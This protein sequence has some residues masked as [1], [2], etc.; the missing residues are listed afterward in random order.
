MNL[1]QQTKRE[2]P[3]PNNERPTTPRGTPCSHPRAEASGS[4]LIRCRTGLHK[5]RITHNTTTLPRPDQPPSENST[6]SLFS[7]GMGYIYFVYVMKVT[8]VSCDGAFSLYLGLSIFRF[9]GQRPWLRI[10]PRI[11]SSSP[12]GS[13]F[14]CFP[15]AYVAL[16]FSLSAGFS[17]SLCRRL[18]IRYLKF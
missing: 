10:K 3:R 15:L 11:L 13:S 8:R 18:S 2:T 16:S 7:G 6:Y 4:C 12:A 1:P 9:G 14:Y 5:K 17:L